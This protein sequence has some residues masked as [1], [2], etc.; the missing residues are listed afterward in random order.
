VAKYQKKNKKEINIE[1]KLAKKEEK[2][3]KN[4]NLKAEKK[5]IEKNRKIIEKAEK[6]IAKLPKTREELIEN[7]FN[8]KIIKKTNVSGSENSA[9]KIP[10][11]IREYGKLG[12]LSES[13]IELITNLI[14][15]NNLNLIGSDY[16]GSDLGKI[17]NE[18]TIDS[19]SE[20][21]SKKINDILKNTLMGVVS[22][23]KILSIDEEN[24]NIEI[25]QTSPDMLLRKKAKDKLVTSNLRLVVS[26]AKKHMNKGVDLNDLIQA[27]YGGLLF[28][29]TKFQPSCN[30]KLG[31]Y[32]T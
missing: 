12:K 22:K 25:F 17:L 19:G 11:I 31:T 8:T 7:V 18:K 14:E 20:K 2:K 30:T 23:S 15:N 1:K 29:I 26:V 9:V 21:I 32:A 5:R 10:F 24:K 3:L 28:S 6:K 13:E 27:G 16:T 4:K